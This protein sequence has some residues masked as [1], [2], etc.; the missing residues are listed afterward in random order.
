MT[1]KEFTKAVN[2]SME[3]I[4]RII[5]RENGI[6]VKI[7]KENTA[8]K[9]LANI[10]NTTLRLGSAIGFQ[11]MSLRDLS[12]ETGLSMGALYSYFS[13]KDEL[14]DII[15][16]YGVVISKKILQGQIEQCPDTAEKLY[17]AIRTHLYLSETLR[18]WFYF[19]YMEAKNLSK[20][21]RKKAIDSEL[22]TEQIFVD[23]LEEGKSRKIFKI[24][25]TI[26]TAAV[27]KAVLQDWYLKRWKYTRRGVSVDD[28][29][30]FIINFIDSYIYK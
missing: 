26:L 15:Q 24:D 6:S 13:S 10:L 4:C 14:I 11:T 22:F 1:Y 5:F 30:A 18:E 12:R 28:Y 23:L 9:N 17:A 8:V 2:I 16:K 19:S 3:E 20:G 29:V 25:N 21:E 27:I 7:K